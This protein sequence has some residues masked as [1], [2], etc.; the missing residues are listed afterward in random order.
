MKDQSLSRVDHQRSLTIVMMRINP[1]LPGGGQHVKTVSLYS[2]Q[3]LSLTTP[4]PPPPPPS[5]YTGAAGS[6]M[7]LLLD[8]WEDSVRWSRDTSG[9]ISGQ[10]SVVWPPTPTPG[11]GSSVVIQ[12]AETKHSSSWEQS[13]GNTCWLQNNI[14]DSWV[15]WILYTELWSLPQTTSSQQR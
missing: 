11:P 6:D 2:L 4:P 5:S 15:Q 13:P 10:S 8:Q 1:A 7:W 12:P 9:P 3:P 14:W